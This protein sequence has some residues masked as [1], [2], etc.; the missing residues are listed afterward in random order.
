M[1]KY[2]LLALIL[3]GVSTPAVGLPYIPPS[4]QVAPKTVPTY[5]KPMWQ[6]QCAEQARRDAIYKAG[7]DALKGKHDY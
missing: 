4:C 6:V 2:A 3:V 1:I 5:D 7:Q